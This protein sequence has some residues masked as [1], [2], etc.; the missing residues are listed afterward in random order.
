MPDLHFRGEKM[1]FDTQSERLFAAVCNRHGYAVEKLATRSERA[2]RTADFCVKTP[3][4]RFLAEVEE[5]T[6]NAED[7]R[8]IREMKNHGAT[9]GGGK[10]G[11]RAREAIRHAAH[12]LKDHRNEGVALIVVLYDHVRTTD[13][14]VAYPM[15]YVE[16]GPDR[17]GGG[18]TM[19]KDEK[20]YISAVA[21]IS[22][23][24]NESVYVYHNCYADVP[25]PAGIF[26]DGK[27]LHFRKGP[28]PHSEPWEWHQVENSVE[29][30]R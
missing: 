24:D 17:S 23:W 26:T 3:H 27:C 8:Q 25:L 9:S 11:S 13:G 4:G 14:R 2:L 5:L 21:V 20:N 19:T 28:E 10:I 6:P 22:D 29:Q 12:Q 7:L 30:S 1:R 16:A 15:Y 18:R